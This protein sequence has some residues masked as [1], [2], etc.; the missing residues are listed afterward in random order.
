[1]RGSAHRFPV[2]FVETSF[3][4]EALP[5]ESEE[6]PKAVLQTRAR[7]FHITYGYIHHSH[8]TGTLFSCSLEEENEPFAPED[9]FFQNSYL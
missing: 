1:M 9:V 6:I 2:F 7:I 5:E 4:Q 8:D 3:A